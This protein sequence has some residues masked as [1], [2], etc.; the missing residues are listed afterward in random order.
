L[1]SSGGRVRVGSAIGRSFAVAA[2][3][4]R[5]VAAMCLAVRAA[6]V[7]IDEREGRAGTRA[8]SAPYGMGP[9]LTLGPIRSMGTTT[10]RLR[11]GPMCLF[12]NS[13]FEFQKSRGS[14]W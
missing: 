5:A 9:S 12:H 4:G 13:F 6:A 8:A 1:A 3:G 10:L 14:F 11:T 7:R 2:D